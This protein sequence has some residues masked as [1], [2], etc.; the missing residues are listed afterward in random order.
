M[1]ES[2]ETSTRC[3]L[4]YE[5]YGQGYASQMTPFQ[6]ALIIFVRRPISTA[7]YEAED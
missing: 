4:M 1:A 3:E 2:R 5:G 6:M 7:G